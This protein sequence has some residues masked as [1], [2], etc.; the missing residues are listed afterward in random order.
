MPTNRLEAFSDGVLAIIITIM[1]LGLKVPEGGSWQNIVPLAPVIL[2]Y[3]LSFIYVGIYWNNHHHLMY[4]TEAVN[5][6]I[7]WANMH[8]LFWLSL[9]PF[10]TAWI[11]ENHIET[12]PVALYGFILFMCAIAWKMLARQIILQEGNDSKV[13]HVYRKDKKKNISVLLYAAGIILAFFI[14]VIS[15]FFYILVAVLWFIPDLR[16]ERE[17]NQNAHYRKL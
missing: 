4:I 7:L 5:G 13:A 17:L 9:L 10:A 6:K 11:G 15:L 3:I 16:I 8:L 14:P 2:T 1:V 12:T